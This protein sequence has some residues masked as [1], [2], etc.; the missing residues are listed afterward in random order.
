MSDPSR[1]QAAA[2]LD[3]PADA[4]EAAVR[5]AFFKK[6]AANNFVPPE[7]GTAA[8]NLLNHGKLPL[9]I[10]GQ[11]EAGRY[12]KADLE[13]LMEKFWQFGPAHRAKLWGVLDRRC[14]DPAVRETLTR[15]KPGLDVTVVRREDW[16]L[17]K[18]AQFIRESFL[19][20]PRERSVKRMEWLAEQTFGPT[21]AA[22][23]KWLRDNDPATT[24][25]DPHLCKTCYCPKR[26]R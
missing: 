24:A 2:A 25:L 10:E 8:L 18:M 7:S 3:V 12:E 22:R 19:L 1:K 23:A 5:A 15:L 9:S 17:D 16:E 13:A 11:L 14:S 21:L 26:R 4:D 6:L 20:P